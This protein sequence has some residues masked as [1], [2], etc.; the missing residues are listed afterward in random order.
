[1]AAF[2]FGA[3]H[4]GTGRVGVAWADYSLSHGVPTTEEFLPSSARARDAHATG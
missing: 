4:F 2:L 1:M 3:Q